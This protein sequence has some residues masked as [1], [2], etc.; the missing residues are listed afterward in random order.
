MLPAEFEPAIPAS[1]RTQTHALGRGY[2]ET[3]TDT[4]RQSGQTPGKEVDMKHI[5]VYVRD[6]TEL[7]A[8]HPEVFTDTRKQDYVSVKHNLLT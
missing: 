6:Y 4:T 2:I 5:T 3:R 7:S 8:Y 1:D